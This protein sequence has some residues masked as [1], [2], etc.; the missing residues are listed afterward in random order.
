MILWGINALNHDSSVAVFQDNVLV[1]HLLSPIDTEL[2]QDMIDWALELGR[3]DKIFW[4]ENP[5]RKKYRQLRAGQF[6]DA[7]DLAEL[8]KI[9]LAQ[10][11]ITDIDIVYG[12]HHGSHAAAGY[13]ASEFDRAVIFVADAIGELDTVS[14]WHAKDNDLKKLYSRRYPYSLGL[15]YSAFTKLLGYRPTKDESQITALAQLGSA[16]HTHDLVKPYLKYNLHRGIRYW[17]YT[18]PKQD[19]A[20]GVQSVFLEELQNCITWAQHSVQTDCCVFMGGCAYNAPARKLF[21]THYK[22]TYTMYL[23][24]DSGSSIGAVLAKTHTRIPLPDID[25]FKPV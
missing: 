23:A 4:Y 18:L 22:N 24:G 7:L 9:Y 25:S 6:A 21:K 2:T 16:Y 19:I 1:K 12:D 15:F 10:F 13:Y 20:A 8:P 11:G 17:P 5:W 14:I 3:P